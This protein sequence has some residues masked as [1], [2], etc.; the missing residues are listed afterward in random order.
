M[1]KMFAMGIIAIF[2]FSI[3][4]FAFAK[5]IGANAGVDVK[6][7]ANLRESM[8]EKNKQRLEKRA[9]LDKEQIDRLSKLEVKNV[10]K[11]SMLKKDRLEK[12]AKLSEEKIARVSDLDEEKLDKVSNLSDEEIT[13]VATL[14]RARM[15]VMAKLDIA[16]LRAEAKMLKIRKVKNGD[17]LAE[18]QISDSQIAEFKDKFEKTKENYSKAKDEMKDARE[19]LRDSVK[20]G[21]QNATIENA[22]SYLLHTAGAIINHLQKVKTQIQENKNI[23]ADAE[24]KIAAQIDAQISEINTIKTEIQAAT[25]KEQVRAAANKL[26]DKWEFLK[27]LINLHAYRVVAARVEGVLNNGIVL[28]KRLDKVVE[29]AKKKGIE[30]N[31]STEMIQFSDKISLAKDKYT[32]AEAKLAAVIDLKAGNATK[33]QI[34]TAADEAKL[35]L[36]DARDAMKDAHDILKEIVKKIKDADKSADLSEDNEV[37]VAE[38]T[39]A[40]ASTGST[41]A[42]STTDTNVNGTAST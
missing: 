28:E 34:K 15:N 19:K 18:R 17:D 11:I 30:I 2:V 8:Q 1:K 6:A 10:E 32:Q 36:K 39:S 16:K 37:E 23:D 29:E 38:E 31:I 21:N 42:T 22:K 14:G 3:I 9:E 4:P 12:I 40:N 27:H 35:L 24:A 41:S 25:A 33:E 7:R 26:H 5:D 20:K 13:K